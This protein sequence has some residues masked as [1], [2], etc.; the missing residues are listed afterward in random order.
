MT[1]ELTAI[2]FLF[3]VSMASAGICQEDPPGSGTQ[4]RVRNLGDWSYPS[5]EKLMLEGFRSPQR[6]MSLYSF[7]QRGIL[8]DTGLAHCYFAGSTDE[9][10]AKRWL[11]DKPFKE[12]L[13]KAGDTME[14]AGDWVLKKTEQGAK[15]PEERA[16]SPYQS[17]GY[18]PT[19][20]S[21]LSKEEFAKLPGVYLR[22]EGMMALCRPEFEKLFETNEKQKSVRA[23]VQA[24][25]DDRASKI[26]YILFAHALEGQRAMFIAHLRR[27]AVD[28]DC[29]IVLALSDV[30]RDR[31]LALIDKSRSLDGL[32]FGAGW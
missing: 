26:N 27:S 31:L 24:E 25:Y 29:R 17:R 2:L 32:V 23:F 13:A 14:Y 3:L 1:K 15:D 18:R 7:C 4:G 6:D 16:L 11:K 22:M 5:D 30:E 19:L 21:L 20:E 9:Y 28:L 12:A 10:L 8:G